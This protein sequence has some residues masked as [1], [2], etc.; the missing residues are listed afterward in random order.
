[1]NFTLMMMMLFAVLLWLILKLMNLVIV[2][3]IVLFSPVVMYDSKGFK[4]PFKNQ[5]ENDCA[6]EYE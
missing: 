6:D 5:E 2:I 4:E 3:V 1:M